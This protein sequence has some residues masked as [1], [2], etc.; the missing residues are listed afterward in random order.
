LEHVP[1]V[2]HIVRRFAKADNF[3]KTIGFDRLN[4]PAMANR[5]VELFMIVFHGSPVVVVV[6][7][8]R[9]EQPFM[10]VLAAAIAFAVVAEQ[11]LVGPITAAPIARSAGCCN[12]FAM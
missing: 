5:F 6:A 8:F 2:L 3:P 9:A 7:G 11:L 10:P 1:V 12:A 4:H